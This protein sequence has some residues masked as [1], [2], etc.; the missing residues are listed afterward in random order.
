[1]QSTRYGTKKRDNNT[2]KDLVA[3]LLLA[4]TAMRTMK[5][6]VKIVNK[7]VHEV[8]VE[9]QMVQRSR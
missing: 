6:R 2:N 7:T 4:T 8:P 5:K 9:V 3:T 1:M